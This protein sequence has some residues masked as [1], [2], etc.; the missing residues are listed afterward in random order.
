MELING[1]KRLLINDRI[2]TRPNEK[3]QEKSL[4]AVPNGYEVGSYIVTEG[5]SVGSFGSVYLCEHK[6]TED[7]YA[8]KFF[9]KDFIQNEDNMNMILSEVSILKEMSNEHT[10]S[11]SDFIFTKLGAF[12][13]M[14]L[15]DGF[16]LSSMYSA[17]FGM[18]ESF[19]RIVF[20]QLLKAIQHMHSLEIVHRD[21]KPENV[22][23]DKL[24]NVK[25]VDYGLSE[26]AHKRAEGLM[27]K[28]PHGTW[29][30]LSPEIAE[31]GLN[32]YQKEFEFAGDKSDIWAAGVL[33]YCIVSGD[34]PFEHWGDSRVL[35]D[36]AENNIFWDVDLSP[37]L[38]DLLQRILRAD[39]KERLSIQEI[40]RHPWMK[41]QSSSEKEK[42]VSRSGNL[43]VTFKAKAA[44]NVASCSKVSSYFVEGENAAKKTLSVRN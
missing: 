15:V 22:M 41:Q 20:E 4:Q 28:R 1:I 29:A 25:L 26:K 35:Y 21:I 40:F 9:D 16:E 39:P 10:I 5:I 8:A 3:E 37:G 32:D 14:E 12:I 7:E 11:Y 24:G 6:E 33:L 17:G 13:V 34:V 42:F 31:W 43:R 19:A 23:V 44:E 18:V 38:R 27:V 36:I 30:Y 2:S